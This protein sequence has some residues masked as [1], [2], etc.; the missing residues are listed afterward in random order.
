VLF[1][2]LGED[3]VL[4]L[5]LGFE[6]F[7]LLLLKG[8]GLLG[9]PAVAGEGGSAVFE[10]S[11]LPEVEEAR[12]EA[13]PFTK[14]GDGDLLEKVFP[15]DGDLLLGSKLPTAA[16]HGKFLRSWLC[17]ATNGKKSSSD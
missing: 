4:A 14:L 7:D 17:L 15:E 2:E 13:V 9:V 3:L 12:L 5:E 1:H 6:A 8:L 16:V 10:E 11:P